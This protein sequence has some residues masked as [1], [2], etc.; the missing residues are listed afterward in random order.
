[1]I[2]KT[3][4]FSV[5]KFYIFVILDPQHSRDGCLVMTKL[6]IFYVI[7]GM[8]L[9]YI[10]AVS[11]RTYL[12]THSNDDIIRN[13][14]LSITIFDPSASMTL[15]DSRS[16]VALITISKMNLCHAPADFLHEQPL[17]I[18]CDRF[19]QPPWTTSFLLFYSV[20]THINLPG[21]TPQSV[22]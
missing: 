14:S 9:V 22:L 16:R 15:D 11:Q 5:G 7:M 13:A 12:R 10:F 3:M 1:M 8:L 4:Q 20:N 19:H 18:S 6:S 21:P 17:I 2:K